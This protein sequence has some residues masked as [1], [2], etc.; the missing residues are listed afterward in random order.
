LDQYT[1][2]ESTRTRTVYNWLQYFSPE[3]LAN[4]FA[5]S[6]FKVEG[7]YGDVAGSAFDPAGHEFAVVARKP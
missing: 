2:V 3:L 4:E 7:F 5:E 6:G 1:I